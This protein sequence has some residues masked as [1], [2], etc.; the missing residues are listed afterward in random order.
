L[1]RGIV[2]NMAST[3]IPLYFDAATAIDGF[4]CHLDAVFDQIEFACVDRPY[5]FT[6]EIYAVDR[7]PAVAQVI[8]CKSKTR[9][10]KVF[11]HASDS[12]PKNCNGIG[13][14]ARKLLICRPLSTRRLSSYGFIAEQ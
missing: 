6:L 2:A 5:R 4:Y 8:D 14:T 1:Q 3:L 13:R 10:L 12:Y 11:D 7:A 9:D